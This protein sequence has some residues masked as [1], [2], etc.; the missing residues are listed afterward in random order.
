[1]PLGDGAADAARGA[2]DDRDTTAEIEKTGQEFLLIRRRL[3]QSYQRPAQSPTI[4]ARG[5]V[6]T[7]T[8]VAAGKQAGGSEQAAENPCGKLIPSVVCALR[9]A[10][11]ARR[12]RQE[13]CGIRRASHGS[14]RS[15]GPSARRDRPAPLRKA[16]GS[17]RSSPELRRSRRV[18]RARGH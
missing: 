16:G 18:H 15:R 2:G 7:N 6:R 14:K 1:E 17:P 4:A 5:P 8:I 12:P 3:D 13:F 11:P 9:A 10:A